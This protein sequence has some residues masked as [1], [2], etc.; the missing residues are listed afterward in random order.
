MV[1]VATKN[2]A[3][4]AFWR[5]DFTSG[6]YGMITPVW[7]Y[8][9]A[10]AGSGPVSGQGSIA[11]AAWDDSG[12]PS[13]LGTLYLAGGI[14]PTSSPSDACYTYQGSKGSLQA[15]N[16]NTSIAPPFPATPSPTWADCFNDSVHPSGDGPVLRAVAAIPNEAIVG[17][18]AWI[19][20]ANES[21]GS[22]T[23]YP[24]PVSGGQFFGGGRSPTVNS[25]LAMP[26]I[27]HVAQPGRGLPLRL[28]VAKRRAYHITRA[29]G[30]PGALAGPPVAFGRASPPR[31]GLP[32]AAALV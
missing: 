31:S 13:S 8:Q 10:I 27:V 19:I 5:A 24:D 12:L 1:G 18:G 26:P 25:T 30:S 7:E 15:F 22:P 2:G 11:P 9:I 20:I 32:R 4:Y 14:P 23:Y 6:P 28:Q 3:F 17:E 21:T 29:T 16:L